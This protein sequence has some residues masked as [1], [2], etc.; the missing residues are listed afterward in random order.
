MAEHGHNDDGHGHI[1]LEYQPALPLNNGKVFL[2]LFLSTEIMFFAA[3][4]GEFIVLR[5]GAP[6]GI[7]P[8]PH[9]VHV[10]EFVGT[11][12]TALLLFSS[13]T[14]VLAYEYAKR[15][16]PYFAKVALFATFI[17]GSAFLGVKGFEYKSK[18]DHGI[19]PVHK[20]SLMHDKADVY[21]MSAVRERLGSL[22]TQ[23]EAQKVEQEGELPQADADRLALVTDLQENLVR[24]AESQAMQEGDSALQQKAFDFSAYAIYPLHADEHAMKLHADAEVKEIDAAFKR[25][26]VQTE[27]LQVVQSTLNKR[28]ESLVA[29]ATQLGGEKTAAEETVAALKAS[30]AKL[31]EAATQENETDD[32]KKKLDDSIAAA[33]S[34]LTALTERLDQATQETQANTTELARAATALAATEETVLRYQNRRILIPKLLESAAHRGLNEE[35]SWLRLPI[36]IPSG[37][38]WASTYFLM[39]GFHAVHVLI[40]LIVFATALPYKLDSRKTNFLENTGLY[41]H[42]VDLVWIFLFPLL[43]LF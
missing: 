21:Y 1:T 23:L 43:Y 33:E 7:W 30:R 20:R 24:W 25:F 18:F 16:K 4:I 11:V 22:R 40:G 31:D 19:Y 41:W 27:S 32:A 29:L 14:I 13:L 12:N 6:N 34:K 28:N 5:F 26:S 37:N 39:T 10:S 38:M 9:D 3:L 2:W 8:T 36:K 17:M 42:F 15:D 35:H